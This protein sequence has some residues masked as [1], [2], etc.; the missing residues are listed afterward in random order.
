MNQSIQITTTSANL[1]FP[2]F[3]DQERIYIIARSKFN[4]SQVA[5]QTYSYL[6][7]YVAPVNKTTNTT[8]IETTSG[9]SLPLIV[10]AAIGAIA[11]IALISFLV[12][13]I[14][15]QRKQQAAK[16]ILN[17][18]NGV[19]GIR[20]KNN[21]KKSQL[22]EEEESEDEDSEEQEEEQ[23]KKTLNPNTKTKPQ[24]KKMDMPVHPEPAPNAKYGA[25]PGVTQL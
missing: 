25:N 17:Q 15:R 13:Y 14:I 8:T 21:S 23:E 11:L 16:D 4:G 19:K 9:L 20:Q 18:Q 12:W 24:K 3:G 1:D 2:Q 22:A 7:K 5:F 10:G 6:D